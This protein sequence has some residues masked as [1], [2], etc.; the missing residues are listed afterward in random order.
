MPLLGKLLPK[1]ESFYLSAT[2]S[3]LDGPIG[4]Q[5]YFTF[6]SI[7]V[8]LRAMEDNFNN[9]YLGRICILSETEVL[10]K[11]NPLG[12]NFTQKPEKKRRGRGSGILTVKY[13]IPTMLGAE[14]FCT[15]A[16]EDR[17]V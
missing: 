10:A 7:Y 13:P 1:L 6:S 14:G 4:P 11:K 9:S 5:S 15:E 8:Y 12:W 16:T 17:M 2:F 3:S